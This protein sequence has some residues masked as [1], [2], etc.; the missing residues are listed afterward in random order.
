M[1]D[2]NS[3]WVTVLAES[4]GI[5]I[6]IRAEI[7]FQNR[8]LFFLLLGGIQV[9][10]SLKINLIYILCHFW[11]THKAIKIVVWLLHS[12]IP[13]VCYYPAIVY[14]IKERIKTLKLAWISKHYELL[15]QMLKGRRKYLFWYETKKSKIWGPVLS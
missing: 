4:I 14:K 7:F 6:G 12:Y 10:I 5:G 13:R 11:S 1:W 8:N 9:F 15:V 2:R 3:V